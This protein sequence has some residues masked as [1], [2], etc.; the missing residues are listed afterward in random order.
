M[1]TQETINKAVA[2]ALGIAEDSSHGYDQANRWGPN[3]DCSS[4]V[5][6]AWQEAG[7]P[8][9]VAGATYTANMY[10]A[11]T[12]CGFE[13]VTNKVNLSTGAGMKKGDVLLNK[14]NHTEMYIGG[15]KVVKASINEKGTVTGGKSGDQ[16]GREIYVGGYYNYP[17]DCVLRF[18]GAET[19]KKEE[20][21]P[22][23]SDFILPTLQLGDTGECVRALQI[24][25]IGRK[26]PCG[27][28]GAD[29]DYGNCTFNAV[30]DFQEKNGLTVDGICGQNT[31]LSLLGVR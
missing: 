23:T 6:T 5:I 17:W 25:L 19:D 9:K 18:M 10:F 22:T 21:A 8:V 3:Y 29:G 14:N 4:F 1:T 24:L 11:F 30:K 27:W 2:W 15:N 13:D 12:K 16:T 26:C 20:S 28:Y 31:W 7:V